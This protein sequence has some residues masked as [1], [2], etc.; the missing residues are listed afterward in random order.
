MIPWWGCCFYLPIKKTTRIQ[1]RQHS[2]KRKQCQLRICTNF[3]NNS[4]KL[5]SLKRWSSYIQECGDNQ[6]EY[7]VHMVV[8]LTSLGW[9][10]PH[11]QT[12]LK[13][14]PLKLKN[15]DRVDKNIAWI[16]SVQAMPHQMIVHAN[17][18]KQVNTVGQGTC[19][20]WRSV[21]NIAQMFCYIR[22][23]LFQIILDKTNNWLNQEFEMRNIR[24]NGNRNIQEPNN[25]LPQLMLHWVW[26]VLR[27]IMRSE[28]LF[29]ASYLE[30]C[31]VQRS[32]IAIV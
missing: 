20:A 6:L 10:L 19:I 25:G 2:E 29:W 4:I 15:W 8:Y 24:Q 3:V 13:L 5:C 18:A 11:K 1:D 7:R 30:K 32:V 27:N 12:H 14:I 17:V 31:F 28:I 21:T 26:I 9:K 23:R 16:T 22:I